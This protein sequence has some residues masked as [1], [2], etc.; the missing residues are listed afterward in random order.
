MSTTPAA[1][2][3]A[4]VTDMSTLHNTAV[5]A[6][7]DTAIPFSAL[8][9]S[10][11]EREGRLRV[12]RQIQ[13]VLDDHLKPTGLADRRV[14]DIGC[15]SGVITSFLANFSGPVVGIDVDTEALRLAREESKQSNLDF[16]FMN[17][18]TLEFPSESFDVVICNQVYYWLDD[19]DRFMAEVYRVLK[20]GG[21]C[22]FASVNKYALWENQYRLPLLSFLPKR[23][24]DV[25]VRAAGKGERFGCRYLSFWELRHLC[26]NFIVHRYTAKVL[27]DPMKYA[28]TRL[29]T[30]KLVLNALPVRLY[31][32]LEP[33]SPN[34]IWV[35]EKPRNRRSA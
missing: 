29:S 20:P 27:K 23:L 17:G 22:Y 2:R 30:V 9:P 32:L 34:F 13:A 1:V 33:L 6:V 15:S 7:R 3:G 5:M 12:A 8:R 31:E 24:A 4:L 28:F 14:L 16:M 25:Y 10:I 26:R 19:P 18:S 21:A 11:L 35:L